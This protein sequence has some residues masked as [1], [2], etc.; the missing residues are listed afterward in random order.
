MTASIAAWGCLIQTMPVGF[1]ALMAMAPKFTVIGGDCH[2][3][4]KT[5][6]DVAGADTKGPYYPPFPAASRPIITIGA[7]SARG[8]LPYGA[9]TVTNGGSGGPV[10]QTGLSVF[11]V[12]AAGVK[13]GSGVVNTNG[14]GVVTSVTVNQPGW[15][16]SGG[17]QTYSII[18]AADEEYW[19][20]RADQVFR[21][22]DWQEYFAWSKQNASPL[23]LVCDDHD[24][25]GD[26]WDWGVVKAG[27]DTNGGVTD[28]AGVWAYSRIALKGGDRIRK[29]YFPQ[30]PMPGGQDAT[31]T[32]VAGQYNGDRPDEMVSGSQGA[33]DG[34]DIRIRYW[35]ADYDA[36]WVLG[37]K[38]HRLVVLDCISY[39]SLL[40]VNGGA[41]TML[42]T[43]QE[44]WLLAAC[45][46]AKTKGFNH[47][48]VVS[49]KD[50]FNR[51][52]Q[53]GWY[54]YA[55]QRDRILLAISNESLPVLWVTFDRHT[56]HIGI[57]TTNG[58]Q[59]Y[60]CLCACVCPM[61]NT[62]GYLDPYPENI[63]QDNTGTN[64]FAEIKINEE[65]GSTDIIGRDSATG[66]VVMLMQVPFG[67]LLPDWDTMRVFRNPN[68]NLQSVPQA[69]GYSIAPVPASN[70]AW[71][72]NTGRPGTMTVDGGTVTAVQIST[73]GGATFASLSN[74]RGS[75]YMRPLD[76]M[77]VTYSVAP[78]FWKF[79][80]VDLPRPV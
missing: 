65:N 64:V 42:G 55:T 45:R 24:E 31:A 79:S 66:D 8:G 20:L 80:P 73:D 16:Y 13:T 77:K 14:S 22:Q 75:F 40:G 26:N 21:E 10:S 12:N 11:F 35:Y 70:A 19:E 3:A 72:N 7:V 48:V 76:Q 67:Q 58:G 27:V 25:L 17:S 1:K 6:K 54:N 52:N 71:I 63:S 43:K 62:G 39:K 61:G 69:A 56:P 34:S 78:T 29:K 59:A 4:D 38:S 47:V 53:D 28:K 44:A 37:G 50:L 57:A 32:L 15:G 33:A 18:C 41:S 74:N 68:Q 46:D 51:T 2:Y 23:Y 60:N 30:T 49:S 9:A 36:N 5:M